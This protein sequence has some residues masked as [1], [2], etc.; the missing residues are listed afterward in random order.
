[1]LQGECDA[2]VRM[3]IIELEIPVCRLMMRLLRSYEALVEEIDRLKSDKQAV[4][5]EMA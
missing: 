1:M 4:V 5:K 2:R 3:N